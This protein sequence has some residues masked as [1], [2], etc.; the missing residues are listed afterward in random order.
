MSL[1]LGWE[2]EQWGEVKEAEEAQRALWATVNRQSVFS[3]RN[4]CK[5]LSTG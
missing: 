2:K 1:D 5:F 4:H 3:G